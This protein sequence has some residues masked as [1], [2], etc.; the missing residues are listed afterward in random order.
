MMPR[1]QLELLQKQMTLRFEEIRAM[2]EHTGNKGSNAEK[3]LRDFLQQ[4]LPP[5][6]RI[7][8]GEVID[9]TGA[10]SRQ[11]D[12][13]ITNEYHPYLNDLTAPSIFII[14]GVS[15]VAEVKSVLNGEELEKALKNSLSFKRLEIAL[16]MET[17]ISHSNPEDLSR[18][19]FKRPSFLFAFES[20][21]S[22]STIKERIE[23]WNKLHNLSIPEQIDGV[24]ILT[25]GSIIN[26]GY[27]TGALAFVTPEGER[28]T[29]YVY[30]PPKEDRPLVSLLSWISA[31][32]I[33]FSLPYPPILAYLVKDI[34]TIKNGDFE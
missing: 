3:I 22:I 13:V 25:G 33:R 28:M 11:I 4:F 19:V 30:G 10:H 1:Q 7:G 34:S 5:Y 23:D 27:G 15:C 8:E 21:L 16:P 18:F 20:K 6:Y 24:F 29:G 31:S 9:Q 26:H 2:Y 32:L 17:E 14:E 12:I